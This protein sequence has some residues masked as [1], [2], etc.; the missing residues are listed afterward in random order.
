M[1][2]VFVPE[3]QQ[4]MITVKL[5][6]A[7]QAVERRPQP[8]VPERIVPVEIGRAQDLVAAV[9]FVLVVVGHV[10]SMPGIVQHGHVALLRAR[11]AAS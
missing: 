8:V 3:W 4:S 6:P 10:R 11:A 2:R 5:T 7:R 1:A 9:G